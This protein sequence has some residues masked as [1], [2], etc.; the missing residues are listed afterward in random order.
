MHIFIYKLNFAL[1]IAV[2]IFIGCDDMPVVSNSSDKQGYVIYSILSPEFAEQGAYVGKYAPYK[3]PIDCIDAK[4][5]ISDSVRTWRFQLSEPGYYKIDSKEFLPLP[6]HTYTLH[7][8]SSDGNSFCASTTIPGDFEVLFPGLNDTLKA[9]IAKNGANLETIIHCSKSDG[10]WIY[11]SW[12]PSKY[13]AGFQSSPLN[14]LEI[15]FSYS[16][17][18][19]DDSDLPDVINLNITIIACD[20]SLSRHALQNELEPA[21]SFPESRASHISFTDALGVFGSLRR[22]EHTLTISLP[23]SSKGAK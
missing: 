17:S 2:L 21:F 18:T 11:Q 9:V 23:D 12:I 10:A 1:L 6:L 4:V 16:L 19:D 15:P 22:V 7:V 3:E 8:Q 20:S 5:A 13:H 14:P